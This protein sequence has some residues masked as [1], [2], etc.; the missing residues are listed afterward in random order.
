MPCFQKMLECVAQALAEKGRAALTGAASFA[1]VLPDIARTTFLYSAEALNDIEQRRAFQEALNSPAEKTREIVR[2]IGGTLP[3]LQ[4]APFRPQVMSYLELL[5]LC[6][7]R[8]LHR[9]SDPEGDSIPEKLQITR[10]EDWLLYLPP[11]LLTLELGEVVAGVDNW[12]LNDLVGM[13]RG[14]E[15]WQGW[16]DS[17]PEM[18]PTLLKFPVDPQLQE[19]LLNRL[20]IFEFLLSIEPFTGMV[21]IRGVYYE[22]TPPCIET[23]FVPGYDVGGMIR[24]WAWRYDRPRPDYA[25]R[26]IRRL[27]EIVGGLHRHDPVIVHRDLK[28]TNVLIHPTGQGRFTVWVS[29]IGW[30]QISAEHTLAHAHATP[31]RGD[32]VRQTMRGGNTS[33]YASPQMRKGEPPDPRDDVYSLGMIWYQLLERDATALPPIGTDWAYR[34]REHGLTDNQVRLLSSC[35]SP[36]ASSRPADGVALME[37][38]NSMSTPEPETQVEARSFVLKGSTSYKP[39]VPMASS[40]Q[41]TESVLGDDD[42]RSLGMNG[43]PHMLRNSVGMN[44]VLIP[45]GTFRMGSPEEEPGHQPHEGPVHTVTITLPF[46]MSMTPVTQAQYEQV[47]GKNPSHFNRWHAGGPDHPVEQVKWDE[48]LTLCTRLS[49]RPEER[50]LGFI[51]RL[52]TE[53]EWEYVCRAGTTT[54][55]A[56]GAMLIGQQARYMGSDSSQF[57]RVGGAGGKT[58]PVGSYMGNP[59]G[60][61][62]MHGNVLEWCADWYAANYYENSPITDPPGPRHGKMKVVRGGS[63][64]QF[65]SECRSATR[66]GQPPDKATNTIG[67]RVVLMLPDPSRVG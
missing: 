15:V 36:K 38:I 67:F 10:P 25:I 40:K 11:Q 66:M 19:A 34:Y 52:P 16:D 58:A 26:L 60:L 12:E 4:S 47:M 31:K 2:T 43:L 30:G 17:L 28:P 55:F 65:P 53:A 13:G 51:Y 24:D 37:R 6:I 61:L 29:D 14:T 18:S 20:D 48:A 33:I 42:G 32:I 27:A 3:I 35:L 9:P 50:E 59:F 44:L 5:P 45:P 56:F 46:Y 7:R 41:R 62:D 63:W 54:A 57:Q 22:S 1:D 8:T 64:S 21:P 23:E 49:S 39:L